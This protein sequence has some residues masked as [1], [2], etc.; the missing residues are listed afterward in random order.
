MRRKALEALGV[1]AGCF[2]V[3]AAQSKLAEAMEALVEAMSGK[4]LVMVKIVPDFQ[5]AC[6]I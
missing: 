5:K 2:A 3:V 6:A 4:V 1:M